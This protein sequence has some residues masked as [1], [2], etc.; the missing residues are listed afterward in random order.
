MKKS[1]ILKIAI[2]LMAAC[3]TLAASAC[4]NQLS[5][6]ALEIAVA[7]TVAAIPPQPAEEIQEVEVTR[8]MEVTTVVQVEITSTPKPTEEVT[9]T[10]TPEPTSTATETPTAERGAALTGSDA[11]PATPIEPSGPLGLSLNALINRYAAMTDLQ[12]EDFA[13]TLPGKTIY[14]TAQVYNVTT[15]GTVIMDNHYGA[16]RVILKGVPLETAI[17]IDKDML[18][19][20]RGMIESFGGTFGREIV[21]IDPEIVRYYV[22][23][24]ITPTP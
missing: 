16:G 14:W 23:P 11:E 5:D 12:K 3:F 4:S 1:L 17:N 19:D 8:V 24:T 10:P 7:E 22:E 18:V 20:F 6:E 21:V 13:T 15:D 2:F 9:E